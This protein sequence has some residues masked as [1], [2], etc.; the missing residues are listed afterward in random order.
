VAFKEDKLALLGDKSIDHVAFDLDGVLID[1][2]SV[3]E[4]SWVSA[5]NKYGLEIPFSSF[6]K[7]IGLPFGASMSNL[8]VSPLCIKDVEIEFSRVAT[9]LQN[10]IKVY[11]GVIDFLKKLSSNQIEVSIVTSKHQKRAVAIIEE[12]FQSVKFNCVVCPE[13][14][15]SGRGKPFPDQLLFAANKSGISIENTLYIGD[16]EIDRMVADSAGCR[17]V[18]AEWG[19]GAPPTAAGLSFKS[20]DNL[21]DFIF[22]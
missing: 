14:V 11:E 17:F 16:T 12:K 20:V 19:Y 18:F 4:K 6:V 7:Q 2:M 8:Q 1:S 10:Q 9:K 22:N 13:S 5:S 21:S 15:N 3:M